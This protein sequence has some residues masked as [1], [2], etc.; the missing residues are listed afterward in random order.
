MRLTDNENTVLAGF[1]ASPMPYTFWDGGVVAFDSSTWSTI[2]VDEMATVLNKTSKS[3][4]GVFSSLVKKG[5][6]NTEHV[7]ADGDSPAQEIV[8]LTDAGV[9]AI[10]ELRFEDE[11]LDFEAELEDDDIEDVEED[12]EPTNLPPVIAEAAKARKAKAKTTKAKVDKPKSTNTRFSHA[13]CDHVTSGR[14]GKIARAKC[15]REQ[16][17]LDH[18]AELTAK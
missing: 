16:H 6:F 7:K 12:D 2:F 18:A 10:A 17:L 13:N 1:N 9:E 11:A 8:T 3:A 15:R 4:R 14:E 5:I